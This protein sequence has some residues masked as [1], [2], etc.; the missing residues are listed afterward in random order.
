MGLTRNRKEKVAAERIAIMGPPNSGKS[1]S[2]RMIKDASNCFLISPSR[3]E[4][5][6]FKGDQPLPELGIEIG[7]TKGW[8]DVM[9]KLGSSNRHSALKALLNSPPPEIKFTGNH[10]WCP[11]M[12]YIPVYLELIDK[13]MPEID[14]VFIGDFTHYIS[15]IIASPEFMAR[16]KGGQAFAR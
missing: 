9:A 16:T 12:M 11:N 3:K 7:N 2:R 5:H 15:H 14:V 1:Y 13:F 4:P 6:L 10:V 8:K